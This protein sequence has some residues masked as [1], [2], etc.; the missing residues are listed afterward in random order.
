MFCSVGKRVFVAVV[1]GTFLWLSTRRQSILACPLARTHIHSREKMASSIYCALLLY[2]LFL[3]LLLLQRK[4]KL[5]PP[6]REQILTQKVAGKRARRREG[7]RE[8]DGDGEEDEAKTLSK[9]CVKLRLCLKET[10]L[11]VDCDYYR[12]MLSITIIIEREGGRAKGEQW[13]NNNLFTL[14]LMHNK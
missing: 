12:H 6:S 11:A 2:L 8:R 1:V 10:A 5:L 14:K 13:H 4:W 9:S 3:L 7:E